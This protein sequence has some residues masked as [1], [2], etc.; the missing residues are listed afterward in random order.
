MWFGIKNENFFA[1]NFLQSWRKQIARKSKRG[2]PE[3]PPPPGPFE[4]L[5]AALRA[6]TELEKIKV[7]QQLKAWEKQLF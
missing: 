4:F 1:E 5:N 3:W 7:E 6:G 2:W